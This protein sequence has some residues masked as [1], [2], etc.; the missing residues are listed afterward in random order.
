[1]MFLISPLFASILFRNQNLFNIAINFFS[2]ARHQNWGSISQALI[3]HQVR[4]YLLLLDPRKAHIK[5]WH[6]QMLLMVR[7]SRSSCALVDFVNSMKKGGLY[8]IGHVKVGDLE[9]EPVDP[10]GEDYSSWLSLVDHLKVKAFV[11][12]TLANSIRAGTEQLVR[13]SGIGAMNP[14]TI[15]LGFRD[16][17]KHCDD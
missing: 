4:K 2:P 12:L 3:F 17:S 8:V 1:M 15:I 11:E 13:V 6:P 14:N 10:C 9:S 7:T 16:T 5:F